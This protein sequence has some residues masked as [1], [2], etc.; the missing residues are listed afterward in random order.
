MAIRRNED[1]KH[2]SDVQNLIVSVILRQTTIFSAEDI[3]ESV[4]NNLER[5]V[6]AKDGARRQEIDV[7]SMIDV[8]LNKL[9]EMMYV[10]VKYD[11]E[12]YKYQLCG[13]WPSVSS[14]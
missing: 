8:T 14:R 10:D 7:K 3:Y 13:K 9:W 6:F 4:E 12:P 1:V 5:S 2:R 11:F